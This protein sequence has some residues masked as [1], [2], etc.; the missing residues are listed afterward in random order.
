MTDL[1]LGL[2]FAV[3]GILNEVHNKRF[4]EEMKRRGTYGSYDKLTG[5]VN[6]VAVTVA[7]LVLSVISIYKAI[8]N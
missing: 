1:F 8:V 4:V 6:R 2:I 5:R 7:F 3:L